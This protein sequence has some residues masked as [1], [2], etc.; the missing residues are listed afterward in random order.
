MEIEMFDVRICVRVFESIL[1][2]FCKNCTWLLLLLE[3]KTCNAELG[4]FFLYIVWHCDLTDLFTMLTILKDNVKIMQKNQKYFTG[5]R[6]VEKE[7]DEKVWTVSEKKRYTLNRELWFADES[8]RA[9]KEMSETVYDLCESIENPLT[10]KYPTTESH[11][12]IECS[13]FCLY[14]RMCEEHFIWNL[15]GSTR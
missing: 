15:F 2:N 10:T 14:G 5:K 12:A 13:G 11:T 9:V 1:N 4:T 7:T 8:I 6:S 3:L